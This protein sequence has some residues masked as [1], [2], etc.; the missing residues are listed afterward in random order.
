[1]GIVPKSE[2]VSSGLGIGIRADSMADKAVA[3]KLDTSSFLRDAFSVELFFLPVIN[4]LC[5][6]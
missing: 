4:F 6:L 1:M 3:C 5:S 2:D